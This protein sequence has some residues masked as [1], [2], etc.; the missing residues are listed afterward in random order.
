MYSHKFL[1]IFFLMLVSSLG[2][3]A[4]SIDTVN[5]ILEESG[6]KGQVEQFPGMVKSGLAQAREQGHPISESVYQNLLSSIDGAV[7][8]EDIMAEVRGTLL[9]ALQ[10]QEAQQLLAWY[11]SPLGKEVTQAEVAATTPQAYQQMMNQ[12]DTLMQDKNRVQ[13]ARIMDELVGGTDMAVHLQEYMR[14]AVYSAVMAANHPGA[15]LDIEPFKAQMEAASGQMRAE[16]EK[17]II[18]S[19]VYAYRNISLSKLEQYETYLMSPLARE[20]HKV[21]GRGLSQGLE[22]AVSKLANAL[23]TSLKSD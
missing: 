18:L 8:P 20:F 9:K 16:T 12:I 23:V 21:V 7:V 3:A 1:V 15:P 2:R 11:Q 4:V 19:T 10:P 13:F 14:I 5:R 22:V 6:L 17:F